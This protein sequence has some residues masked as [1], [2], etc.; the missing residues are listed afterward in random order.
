LFVYSANSDG[1]YEFH[2]SQGSV[3]TQLRCVGLFSNHFVA[4]F[5]QNAPVKKFWELIN[6]FTKIWTKLCGLFF[7]SPCT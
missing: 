3:A 1:F 7:G 4:N 2:I 5:S 6:F